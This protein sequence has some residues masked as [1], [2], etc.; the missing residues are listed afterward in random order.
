MASE[1][2]GT[3]WL[4]PQVGGTG[5]R[6][7]LGVTGSTKEGLLSL[8][9]VPRGQQ[10][11]QTEPS[12]AGRELLWV[13][14]WILA[15]SKGNFGC[16]RHCSIQEHQ[17]CPSNPSPNPP[18]LSSQ[19]SAEH[20]KVLKVDFAPAAPEVSKEESLE[21]QMGKAVGRSDVWFRFNEGF[22]NAVRRNLYIRDLL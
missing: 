10:Q 1:L 20:V 6:V 7:A 8:S 16:W 18:L 22:S 14:P 5:N 21:L 9:P 17:L 13:N 3:K 11:G 15:L 2:G 19:G 12:P 4:Q